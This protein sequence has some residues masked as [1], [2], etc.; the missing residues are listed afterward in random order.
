MAVE[1][2]VER[3]RVVEAMSAR[4]AVVQRLADACVSVRQKTAEIEQLQY[5][6]QQ[7]QNHGLRSSA[8]LETNTRSPIEV[9]QKPKENIEKL[10]GV[11]KALREEIHY[12]NHGA[13]HGAKLPGDLP[14]RYEEGKV[15]CCKVTHNSSTN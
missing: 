5:E 14:P 12:L 7:Y 2:Q 6:Q 15:D 3:M 4:D 10:E 1:I 9:E 13:E 8:H 11:I